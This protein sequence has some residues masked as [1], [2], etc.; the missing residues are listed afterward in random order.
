MRHLETHRLAS[1][2]ARY[3][4]GHLEPESPL[5]H[6][7]E[8]GAVDQATVDALYEDLVTLERAAATDYA[9]TARG[10]WTTQAIVRALLEYAASHKPREPV[11]D[12]KSL[13]D[14]RTAARVFRGLSPRRPQR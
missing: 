9:P 12:W 13:Q 1:T 3:W 10:V 14:D 8:T 5:G 11:P 4:A 7:A 2:L 6:F